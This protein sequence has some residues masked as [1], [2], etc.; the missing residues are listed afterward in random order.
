MDWFLYRHI[1][2]LKRAY[3]VEF[4]IISEKGEVEINTVNWFQMVFKQVHWYYR[5]INNGLLHV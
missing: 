3:C 4:E 2:F 1:E 5:H